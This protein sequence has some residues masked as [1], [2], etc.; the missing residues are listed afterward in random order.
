MLTL[1]KNIPKQHDTCIFNDNYNDII[2]DKSNTYLCLTQTLIVEENL[3]KKNCFKS[4]YRN[5][6]GAYDI[7]FGFD[8]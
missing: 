1:Q 5:Q 8:L 7:E 4:R 6:H 2:N 3:S